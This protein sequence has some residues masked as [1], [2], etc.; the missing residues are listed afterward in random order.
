MV[1]AV[2]IFPIARVSTPTPNPLNG[3]R[4]HLL[5]MQSFA[6]EYFGGKPPSLV[7][8]Y[9]L[10][11]SSLR[12]HIKF[13]LEVTNEDIDVHMSVL[14]D[15]ECR[16]KRIICRFDIHRS[17]LSFYGRVKATILKQRLHHLDVR[18][19][20]VILQLSPHAVTRIVCGFQSD[21][22]I[23]ERY[24]W[25]LKTVCGSWSSFMRPSKYSLLPTMAPEHS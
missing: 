23:E 24:L 10:D 16:E 6:Y 20:G 12:L 25:K 21:M 18:R 11:A 3:R 17:H 15:V 14:F 7:C 8:R 5:R 9:S 22:S 19:Y 2:C 4:P 13:A 1:F